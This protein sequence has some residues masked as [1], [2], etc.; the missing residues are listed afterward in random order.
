MAERA[1]CLLLLDVNN[2]Y[3]SARNHGFDPLDYLAGLPAN[4]I[5]QIH[6]AG[7]SDMGD[8]VI[9]THD[10]DVCDAVWDLYAR[11][12][13]MF[14]P[15][16]TMIERDDNIPPLADVVAELDRA[17]TVAARALERADA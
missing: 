8:Y 10:A 7:H 1:D 12:I 3:V 2:I 4:R 9:D 17:R 16:A 15:I 5:Q 11:A 13:H 14:G 6:L